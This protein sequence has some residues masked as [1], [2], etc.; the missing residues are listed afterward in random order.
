MKKFLPVLLTAA[1]LSGC[2]SVPED[3]PRE[4]SGRAPQTYAVFAPETASAAKTAA[5]E[6]TSASTAPVPEPKTVHFCA[7]GDNIIHS[8]IYRQAYSDG[9]YDFSRAYSEIE[10]IISAA[11]LAVINQ[12]TL[13]CNDQ[14]EPSNYP[15]FNTPTT[16]GDHMISI[17]FDAFTLANNHCLDY[18]E[19]GLGHTLDYWESRGVPTAG[20]YRKGDRGFSLGEYNG[21]TFSFLSYTEALNGFSLPPDSEFVIGSTWDA[22]KV[23]ADIAAAKEVSDVC[24]VALHWGIEYSDVITDSQREY[25]AMLSEAGAD[26]II[27]NHPHVMRG[28]EVIRTEERDTVCAYSLG[29]FISAQNGGANMVSGILEFDIVFAGRSEKIKISDIRLTPIVTHYDYGYRN[30]R[31]MK[32][33]DYTPELA[34]AH[35]VHKYDSFSYDFIVK[36]LRSTI[37]ERFLAF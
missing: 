26:I 17:G 37:D 16:L 8:P 18:G 33:S 24:V 28:I 23:R 3:I 21:V 29:N 34:A 15:L 19:E 35:G 25:A 9:K 12:E 2:G 7:V 10:D 5:P 32:L 30:L 14:Y 4:T 1:F 22:E 11:D 6:E 31:I 13:I 27:G 20:I 36:L